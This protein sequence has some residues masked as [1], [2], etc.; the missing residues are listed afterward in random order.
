MEKPKQQISNEHLKYLKKTMSSNA[1]FLII[2]NHLLTKEPASFIRF[3]DGDFEILNSIK[4]NFS[5]KE[6]YGQEWIK[7]LGM[8]NI[9]IYKLAE[10]ILEAGNNAKYIAPS[11]SGVNYS[12]F[13]GWHFFK[14]RDF[15]FDIFSFY[16]FD[17][18][19]ID[20]LYKKSN[21][22]GVITRNAKNI[23]EK[24]YNKYKV[25]TDCFILT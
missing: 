13:D 18:N 6:K 11:I 4:Y 21:G 3:A 25:N 15:Y 12:I 23:S 17:E 7:D 5:L 9:N 14:E 16:N 2:Y 20:D 10:D 22:V 1:L 8:E 19:M 24:I